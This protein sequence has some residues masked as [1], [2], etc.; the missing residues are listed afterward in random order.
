MKVANLPIVEVLKYLKQCT[1]RLDIPLLKWKNENT[2][3]CSSGSCKF[4]KNDEH[5]LNLMR[6]CQ[7]ISEACKESVEYLLERV[8]P[9]VLVS[10]SPNIKYRYKC[11]F[12][13]KDFSFECTRGWRNKVNEHN[14]IDVK[15]FDD[16]EKDNSDSDDSVSDDSDFDN[17]FSRIHS[18]FFSYNANTLGSK[19]KTETGTF[20]ED[21]KEHQL[22]LSKKL[23]ESCS[24]H[25]ILGKIK[26]NIERGED[27]LRVEYDAICSLVQE[28][29]YAAVA[30]AS[31]HFR[32]TR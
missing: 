21:M 13:S 4:A 17:S 26:F 3:S 10:D 9:G 24:K 30:A 29:N 1:I 23:V 16:S 6:V 2:D 22:N 5:V 27:I 11:V 25:G 7:K 32:N 18:E 15:L 19:W 20:N 8:K 12:I 31:R 14:F 28:R